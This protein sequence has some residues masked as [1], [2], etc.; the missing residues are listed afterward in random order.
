MKK[1]L[2]IA[3]AGVNHNGYLKKCFQLIDI[4]KKVGADIVKF[5]T[6]KAK[7]LATKN[8]PKAN[9]Q[10]KFKKNETQF[11]MLEKLELSEQNHLKI[12]NYC[13]KKKIEFLS[14]GFDIQD[15]IFLKKLNLKR[16][17]IPSG[18]ITNYMYLKKIATF[19][20]EVILSTGMST[21]SEIKNAMNILI[22]N[23]L[24]HNKIKLLHC[25]SDYPAKESLINLRAI[26]TMKKKFKVDIGYSDHTKSTVVPALA[27][28]RGAKIIE[29]HLT[30]NNNSIGPDHKSSLNPVDFSKMVDNIRLAELSLGDG[31]KRPNKD[32]KKNIK[33]VRKS[34]VAKKNIMKGQLFTLNNITFKRPGFGLS[35][36]RI[37]KVLGRKAKRNFKQDQ[38][39][40]I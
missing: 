7:N 33:I 24:K 6:F 4:A 3:E 25:S 9:Y 29:K 22:K 11:Q 13:V 15:L 21:L 26:D 39:I 31:L 19:K 17:K 8:S 1:T 14:S 2:I 12:K 28:M 18:E 16:F 30:L 37:K 20:K 32:E 27:V 36:M 23:G 5:Q 10:K 34:I 35:P 38:F 40:K